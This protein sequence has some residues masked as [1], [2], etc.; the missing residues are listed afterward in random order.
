ME[1]DTRSKFLFFKPFFHK[2]YIQQNCKA[3][4]FHRQN[5]LQ[6][7]LRL[8]LRN[9]CHKRGF[10]AMRC[11]KEAI[12]LQISE[13]FPLEDCCLNF[14]HEKIYVQQTF[15]LSSSSSSPSSSSSSSKKTFKLPFPPLNCFSRRKPTT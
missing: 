6:I 4:K 12:L 2:D 14:S 5:Y 13:V 9:S 1:G 3:Q 8:A 7:K 10:F 11:V 15:T